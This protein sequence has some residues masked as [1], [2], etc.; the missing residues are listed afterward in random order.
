MP[1]NEE[2]CL[3]VIS[4]F[5]SESTE[6]NDF[7][8]QCHEMQPCVSLELGLSRKQAQLLI[9]QLQA[10]C[11]DLDREDADYAAMVAKEQSK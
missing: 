8:A 7:L 9:S 1:Q 2:I 5:P 3:H 4:P 10:A 6:T 11:Q